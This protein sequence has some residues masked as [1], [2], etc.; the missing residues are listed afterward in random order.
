MGR[1][2]ILGG[3][4]D[5]GRSCAE[6]FGRRG[7]DITM[8]YRTEESD[9]ESFSF[10][11]SQ[12]HSID[13][14]P[15]YFD[16]LDY[17]S[18]QN[19]LDSQ[20]TEIE[21]VISLFGL[22]GD[23]NEAILNFHHSAEIINTNLVANMSI[24]GLIANQMEKREAGTIVCLSSVAGIRGRQSNY[25]Y[26]ASK[27]GLTTFLSGLRSR[28]AKYNVHVITIIP[29]YI[30][31]KM[32]DHIDPPTFLTASSE[33]VAASIHRAIK[34]KRNVVYVKRM[35]QW[36]MLGIRCIPEPIFKKLNL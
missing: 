34:K 3:N 20:Y 33:Q 28:L 23:Q 1:L 25:I 13:V 21:V 36:I 8:T 30:D 19:F 11:L 29:G 35:W 10:E 22:L 16:A 14:T 27:S 31:T 17:S 12:A 4:S 5:V 24:L 2:L 18:H 15:V 9:I 7:Y 6:L 26:G 32:I